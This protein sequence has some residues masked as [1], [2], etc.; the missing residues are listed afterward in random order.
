M[1]LPTI[2]G[3]CRNFDCERTPLVTAAKIR[4]PCPQNSSLRP[5]AIQRHRFVQ[6]QES[7]TNRLVRFPPRSTVRMWCPVRSGTVYHSL[8]SGLHR[9]PLLA[10][11]TFLT[12]PPHKSCA[13]LYNPLSAPHARF[14][15]ASLCAC[16][17][18]FVPRMRHTREHTHTPPRLTHAFDALRIGT[19]LPMTMRE[20]R[21]PSLCTRLCGPALTTG[22]RAGGPKG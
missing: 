16:A 22:W 11:P 2:D 1:T 21:A 9:T 5:S 17:C 3:S 6:S 4:I 8:Q 15:C 20:A 19:R 12:P 14:A 13:C 7:Y 10:P 18:D